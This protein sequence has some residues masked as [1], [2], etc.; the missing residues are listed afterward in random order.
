MRGKG[1]WL[2]VAVVVACLAVLAGTASAQ[3][4]STSIRETKSFEVVSVDGN[5][6]VVKGAEGAKELTVTDDF[7]LDV[8][9]RKVSVRELKPGMKGTATITTTTTTTP[10][11][12]TE[13]R[14]GEVIKVTG[15]SVIIRS[16]ETGYRAYN[17]G[18]LNKRNVQI[19]RDGQPVK[20]SDLTPGNKLT[21]TIVT[22]KE[23]A[24]LTERQV[25]ANIAAPS[26]A[27]PSSTRA[28][29]SAASAPAA[30]STASSSTASTSGGQAQPARVLPKTASPLP[31]LGLAGL[32]LL[33]I[34]TALRLQLRRG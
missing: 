5:K 31:L 23:P 3:Q 17:Q 15:G 21:A 20:L 16:D 33:A 4:S 1:R 29:S 28:T 10:V 7:Q 6:V 27:A 25:Q 11:H 9:G 30:Q 13:V 14:N 8:G 26:D 18:D 22:E 32:A 34:G 19:F 2:V 24:V 12:V